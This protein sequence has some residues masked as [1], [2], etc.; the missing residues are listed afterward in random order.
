MSSF[1]RRHW[2]EIAW[3]AF[4]LANLAA[5]G[6]LAGSD[7]GTVPF[8][9]IWVSLTLLY[10]YT[11]WR[12]GLTAVILALVMASTSAL[13]VLE[14]VRGPT[15]LDELTEVPLMAAMFAAMVWH[16]RRRAAA[17]QEAVCSRERERDFIRDSSHHLKAPLAVAHGY[18]ELIRR[19]SV[20][21]AQSRSAGVLLSELDRLTK[22][23]DGMLLFVTTEQPGS[24][25]RRPVD[26]ED[27]VHGVGSRWMDTVDRRIVVRV[28]GQASLFGDRERL[29]CALDALVENAV[30]ATEADDPIWILA[31]SEGDVVTIRVEDEGC[32]IR[33]EALEHVFERLWSEA[34]RRKRRG[35]GLGLAIVKAIVEAHQGTVR[36]STDRRTVFTLELP[37]ISVDDQD[38]TVTRSRRDTHDRRRLRTAS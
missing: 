37:N 15:R 27:L 11:L 20:T 24:L 16:A 8:H 3:V 4:A 36:V 38:S 12:I 31:S 25:D 6:R 7:G 26:L 2:L 21:N 35:T 33:R 28:D 29:E 5:M 17:E 23:V 14:V 22:I 18:A 32:G 10:G 34:G 9:F 30:D 1:P 13:I 19:G